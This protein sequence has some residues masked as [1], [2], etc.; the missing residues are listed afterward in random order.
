MADAI[1]ECLCGRR[2]KLRGLRSKKCR[3]GVVLSVRKEADGTYREYA[4]HPES[5]LE[6]RKR[7]GKPV[8]NDAPKAW[9]A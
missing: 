1:V 3:C 6:E 2:H 5:S 4:T 8:V 9:W 7:R